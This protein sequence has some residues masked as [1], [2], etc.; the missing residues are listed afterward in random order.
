VATNDERDLHERLDRALETITARPAPVE[1]A[2][3]RGRTI[4]RRR[5]WLG[6]AAAAVAC[7]GLV[8]G[9][10]VLVSARPPE[11]TGSSSSQAVVTSPGAS[12]GVIASGTIDGR[13]WRLDARA[14]G[15]HGVS[16]EQEIVGISG[17]GWGDVGMYQAVPALHAPS[18]VPVTFSGISSTEAQAQYGAIRADVSYV[19][20][21]LS[22]GGVL[23]LQPVRLFGVRVVGFAVPAAQKITEAIAYSRDGEIAVAIP[24][25]D[26]GGRAYFGNWLRPGQ[27]AGPRGSRLIGSGTFTAPA[28]L[29]RQPWSATAYTGPWGVCVKATSGGITNVGCVTDTSRPGTRILFA[30]VGVWQVYCGVATPAVTRIVVHRPD[31]SSVQ[32]RPVAVGDHKF[33]AVGVSRGVGALSWTA[34]DGSG[35]VVASS[36]V[37]PGT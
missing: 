24:F 13:S 2:I 25:N 37:T 14:P 32:V 1:D 27:Q 15:T 17:P 21:R 4:R 23:T 16:A 10:V 33:F 6:A 31:G 36:Q 30:T 19:K 20:V 28:P 34:Y 3:R 5:H 9:L 7:A 22:D 8:A 29:G 35:A 12:S 11:K 18:A 26:P